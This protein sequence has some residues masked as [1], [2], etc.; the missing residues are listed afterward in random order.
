MINRF[1]TMQLRENRWS[2]EAIVSQARGRLKRAGS[3]SIVFRAFEH[4]TAR[5]RTKVL[6]DDTLD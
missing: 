6:S 1:V 3:D 4:R 2:R 5:L